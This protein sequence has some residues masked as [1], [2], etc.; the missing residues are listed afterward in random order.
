M[1]M[2]FLAAAATR[3]TPEQRRQFEA[4]WTFFEGMDDIPE[5]ANKGLEMIAILAGI[6]KKREES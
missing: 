2:E 4:I 3:L 5:D 1:T 6:P